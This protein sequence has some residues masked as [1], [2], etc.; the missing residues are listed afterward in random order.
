MRDYRDITR[1]LLG[2]RDPF[3]GVS[4]YDVFIHGIK[5]YEQ[6]VVIPKPD[7][8][9]V[10]I[11]N[12]GDDRLPEHPVEPR[13][14]HGLTSRLL[15][16]QKADA[17]W[18]CAELTLKQLNAF[19]LG[20]SEYLC[21]DL[22]LKNMEAASEHPICFPVDNPL[23]LSYQPNESL[24]ELEKDGDI[25]QKALNPEMVQ[26]IEVICDALLQKSDA[27]ITL[28]PPLPLY[29]NDASPENRGS[30]AWIATVVLVLLGS[31]LGVFY[32]AG[33]EKALIQ[34]KKSAEIKITQ[35]I[36][37]RP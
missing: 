16:K 36:E 27:L 21:N 7:I 4:E 1:Y 35:V 15:K 29:L 5:V 28:A 12:E 32:R 19:L 34:L 20:M 11:L 3:R 6:V 9:L 25:Y 37:R 31:C 17:R 33:V 14:I 8:I 22:G 26:E 30:V 18:I 2:T 23:R 10:G 24:I 13:S